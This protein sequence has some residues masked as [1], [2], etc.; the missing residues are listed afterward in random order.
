MGLF[1]FFK[2]KSVKAPSAPTAET[3]LDRQALLK[4]EASQSEL[5][6]THQSQ[7]CDDCDFLHYTK[8]EYFR[9][10]ANR[11]IKKTTSSIADAHNIARNSQ[12]VVFQY[13]SVEDLQ[14]AIEA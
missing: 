13:I 7:F 10:P 2:K 4:H 11:I 12:T 8:E 3:L 14:E 5:I 1:D 6:H 9:T